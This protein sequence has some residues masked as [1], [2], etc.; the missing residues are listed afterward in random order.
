MYRYVIS[1]SLFIFC[2]PSVFPQ[3]TGNRGIFSIEGTVID[4]TSQ[5]V[6]EY[7]SVELRA[8]KDSAYI[9]GI[10]TDDKGRFSFKNVKPTACF[11]NVS[12]IGYEK[13]VIHLAEDVFKTTA[14][15]VREKELINLE[16]IYLN[17][18]TQQLGGIEIVAELPE[19]VV[20][21]DT[22][23]YNASA[24][25]LTD[26]AVVEDLLKRL[27]GMEVDTE[28]K[29]T[30]NTGK[31]VRRVFVDGKEFFGND[32]KMATRNL[33]AEMVDKV[34]VV[35]KKSDLSVLTGVEDDDPETIINITIKKGMK[36]GWIGNVN[37]GGGAIINNE[38]KEDARYT[39]NFNLNKFT[40]SDQITFIAN[41]NNINQRNS[42]DRGNSVRAGRGGGAGGNGIISSNTFGIN[43]NNIVNDKLK[44]GSSVQYNYSDNYVNNNSYR[45]TFFK[46]DSTN[47]R[48][49]HSSDRD[50]TNNFVFN[51]RLEYAPD[52]LTTIIFTPSASYN[53]SSSNTES[54]QETTDGA[55]SPINS[56]KSANILDSKG[57]EVRAQLDVSRKLSTEG[58]RASLSGWFSLN[59]SGGD[60][61]NNSENIFARNHSRDKILNQQS[62]TEN[63]RS[64]YNIRATYVEPIG[65]KGNFLNFSYQLQN[66]DTENRRTTLDYDTLTDSY[67]ILNADYSKSSDTR[68]ITQNIRANFNSN[69]TNYAYNIGIS[70]SPVFNSSRNFI[71][72]WHG[73]GVDSVVNLQPGRNTTNYAPFLEYTYRFGNDRIIRKNLKLRYNG[74]S[75]QPSV[76]QLDPS[77]NNTNPLNIRS[78][79]PDLLPSFDNSMSL[80]YNFNNR[81]SQRSF[82]S[83]L[84]YSFV[85]NSIIN[86]TAY[87]SETGIQ[88]TSPINENGQW[89]SAA[90]L[91]FS[92]PF[93]KKKKLKFTARANAGYNN[94]IQYS[95]AGADQSSAR[96]ISNTLNVRQEI[97]LSYSNDWYYGQMRANGSMQNTQ[98][99]LEGMQGL[100]TYNFSLSYNM[101]LTLPLSFTVATDINY[102]GN[103]GMAQGYNKN[104]TLWNAELSK[105]FLKRNQGTLRFQITDILHQRLNIR[106][107]VGGDYIQDSEFTALSSYFMLT[108]TYR[109]NQMGGG[110]RNRGEGNFGP[111]EG[112]GGRQWG[113]GGGG[114][115]P[116]GRE[117]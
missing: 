101:Q 92:T 97:N 99:S 63:N 50:Y 86:Y 110:R 15:N 33:T 87:D 66:N 81:E 116:G 91:M 11:V 89:S 98:Y 30:S 47:L 14:Q 43:T 17:P 104:E 96:Y 117:F 51:G 4:S 79:N 49:S 65:G 62:H 111:P 54:Q 34:Q 16:Q 36:R 10:A 35:E 82:T 64:A 71:E 46:N 107:Q 20:K 27:P 105:Q 80:E 112:G 106:R 85:Q 38:M 83:T 26:G 59:N 12:F 42:G 24:F 93:D 61:K 57:L 32:P 114:G 60:G 67:S 77:E 1:I 88:H 52:T 74:Q 73:D 13:R 44:F 3:Q 31:E 94:N 103:R 53:F 58:R 5:E 95:R 90:S 76:T 109:F 6:L 84:Q 37:G 2:F 41:A 48:N 68:S 18:S 45:Q 100:K 19:M 102:S 23:E 108:F 29:I 8:L 9:Q 113:G 69:K 22:I 70:V 25:R 72:D 21:E 55:L 75:R 78:G 115:F 28:G 56:S 39:T 7:A 40:D